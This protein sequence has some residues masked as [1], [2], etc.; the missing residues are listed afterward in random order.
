MLT[1]LFVIAS[2]AIVL[3]QETSLLGLVALAGL[4]TFNA[5]VTVA[6]YRREVTFDGRTLT[7]RTLL[8]TKSIDVNDVQ[9]ATVHITNTGREQVAV[10]RSERT[11]AFL[12]F[13][14]GW[15]DRSLELRDLLVKLGSARQA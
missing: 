7:K 2:G 13:D 3:T 11:L 6:V 14:I 1:A 5:L 8:R 4:V 10:Y 12:I 15:W 9:S